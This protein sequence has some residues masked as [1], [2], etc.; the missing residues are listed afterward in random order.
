[1][2]CHEAEK[3]LRGGKEL[4]FKFQLGGREGVIGRKIK[5]N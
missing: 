2:K 1:M 5:F 3:L 4:H